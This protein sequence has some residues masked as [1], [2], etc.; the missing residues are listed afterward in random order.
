MFWF[1]KNEIYWALPCGDVDNIEYILK[2]YSFYALT[3]FTGVIIANNQR[4]FWTNSATVSAKQR[5]FE[6]AIKIKFS[7]RLD[8]V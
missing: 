1:I 5:C 7:P 8:L 4:P 3:S 2:L 6:I